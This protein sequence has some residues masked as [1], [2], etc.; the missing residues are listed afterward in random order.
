MAGLGQV[1][2]ADSK[3]L[4][5]YDLV[6]A[7]KRFNDYFGIHRER[8][9]V[10]VRALR[11]IE[12]ARELMLPHEYET[13]K[14]LCYKEHK[15]V[16]DGLAAVRAPVIDALRYRKEHAEKEWQYPLAARLCDDSIPGS[17]SPAHEPIKARHFSGA[18]KTKTNLAEDVEF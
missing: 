6:E 11:M 17:L 18:G 4:D 10:A 1:I 15:E 5:S 8:I 7:N 13:A 3:T 16:F 12:E 14:A 2:K 9:G